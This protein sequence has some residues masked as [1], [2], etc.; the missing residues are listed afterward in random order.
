L[1]PRDLYYPF[2][3]FIARACD[4]ELQSWMFIREKQVTCRG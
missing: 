4:C 2:I 1:M 3:P